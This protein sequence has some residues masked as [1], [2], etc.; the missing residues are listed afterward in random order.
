MNQKEKTVIA[1]KAHKQIKEL[2]TKEDKIY[3]QVRD[4]LG[5]LPG[6]R[7]DDFLFDYLFNCFGK[8][9][10]LFKKTLEEV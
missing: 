9:K 3:I 1:R 4:K 6:S 2:K 8:V 10:N 5:F 7:Q